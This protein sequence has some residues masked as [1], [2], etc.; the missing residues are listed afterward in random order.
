MNSVPVFYTFDRTSF[1]A[2]VTTP[3]NPVEVI[4]AEIEFKRRTVLKHLQAGVVAIDSAGNRKEIGVRVAI[5]PSA[6]GE[7][8]N[9]PP[10]PARLV[11]S[12]GEYINGIEMTN[13]NGGVIDYTPTGGVYIDT[14]SG[15]FFSVLCYG[16]T[17]GDV[18]LGNLNMIVF[19]EVD[20]NDDY[21]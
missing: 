4:T 3:G 21:S 9:P 17:V 1:S 19:P 14:P 20:C 13:N 18:V 6:I 5:F 8:I 16:V 7:F 2:P 11:V 12:Q 15:T 10:S